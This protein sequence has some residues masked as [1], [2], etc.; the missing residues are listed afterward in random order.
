MVGR[1]KQ[2]TPFIV[3]AIPQ[4][5]QANPEA[6]VYGQWLAE[7]ISDNID[8]LIEIGFSAKGIVTDNHSANVNA[9]L[10]LYNIQFRMKCCIKHI[11]IL[12][13]C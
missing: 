13:D 10:A 6:T 2:S 7:E 5:S 3:Q 8:N 1:L 11:L 12:W 9:F 4:P